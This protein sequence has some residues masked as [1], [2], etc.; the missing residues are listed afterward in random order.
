MTDSMIPYSFIPGTKAKA[1]EV[2]ANFLSLANCLTQT[3]N[4][5]NTAVSDI[6]DLFNNGISA[7]QNIEEENTDLNDYVKKGTYFFSA[8]YTPN[9]IPKS[10]SGTLIT[11]GNETSGL[12]QIWICGDTNPEIFVRK[13]S[14]SG[15]SA[16]ESILG[17]NSLASKTG[18]LKMPN[19]ILIQ[20]GSLVGSLITYPIAYTTHVAAVVTKQGL[21]PQ[22]SYS[23]EGFVYQTLTGCQ[24]QSTSV[25]NTEFN[26]IAIGF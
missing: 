23:D 21:I 13:Y 1:N 19:G 8:D 22:S 24:Y 26:W 25:P 5:L 15:W 4:E 14:S 17:Q 9:N 3:Q 18:Y 12:Q 2:N 20:W 16:W 10:T 11:Q 6:S 7:E